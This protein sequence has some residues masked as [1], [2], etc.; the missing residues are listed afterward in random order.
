MAFE[1]RYVLNYVKLN[2]SARQAAV[3]ISVQNIVDGEIQ[4]S[5]NIERFYNKDDGGASDDGQH[6]LSDED[7]I[8]QDLV[9]HFWSQIS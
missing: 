4:Q 2:P 5:Y 3:V 9:N 1:R 7:T 8:A 6:Q